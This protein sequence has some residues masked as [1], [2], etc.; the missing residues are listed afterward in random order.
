MSLLK[1]DHR[2]TYG[3]AV[4]WTIL[5][6]SVPRLPFLEGL[7]VLFNCASVICALG[8]L[9]RMHRLT[10]DKAIRSIR[11]FVVLPTLAWLL[12][13]LYIWS[14]P[15][16]SWPGPGVWDTMLLLSNVLPAITTLTLI[17]YGAATEGSIG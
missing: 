2:F 11:W 4:L 12:A 7:I 1:L 9:I 8:V 14:H 15:I 3:I 5:H 16:Y 17:A 10:P 13:T 6:W